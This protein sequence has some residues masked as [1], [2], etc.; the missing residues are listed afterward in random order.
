M[1]EKERLVKER[2]KTIKADIKWKRLR[3]AELYTKEIAVYA[4]IVENRLKEIKELDRELNELLK[5]DK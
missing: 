4:E 5:D 1:N 2:I 3:I